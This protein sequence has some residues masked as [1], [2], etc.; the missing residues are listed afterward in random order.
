[1]YKSRCFF[2]GVECVNGA[3]RHLYKYLPRYVLVPLYRYA[4]VSRVT[5]NGTADDD[6]HVAGGR[7]FCETSSGQRW[8][9]CE[10]IVCPLRDRCYLGISVV[11]KWGIR[12]YPCRYQECAS[13]IIH[14]ISDQQFQLKRT[15]RDIDGLFW[16]GTLGNAASTILHLVQNPKHIST[17][18]G[19]TEL[20]SLADSPQS[21]EP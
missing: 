21:F 16:L 17:C 5:H 3:E 7:W 19:P 1:M 20:C 10:V 4:V 14:A 13:S 12:L 18:H 15:L 9:S 8:R 11:D 6:L 2:P